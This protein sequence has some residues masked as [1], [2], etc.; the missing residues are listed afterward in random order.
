MEENLFLKE[1]YGKLSDKEIIHKLLNEKEQ[2]SEEAILILKA[3]MKLRNLD[4]KKIE[5]QR[6]LELQQN[7][8]YHFFKDQNGE[9]D[10]LQILNTIINDK[11]DGI[12]NDEIVIKF[13]KQGINKDISNMLI[14]DAK[15]KCISIIDDIWS[16]LFW[17]AIILAAGIFATILTNRFSKG[18]IIFLPYGAILYGLIKFGNGLIKLSTR[19]ILNSIIKTF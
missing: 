14:A 16:N 17:G 13:E 2:H 19:K 15:E 5:L 11:K 7:S 18:T 3:E 4:L 12:T 8:D 9:N 1:F 6:T 10:V